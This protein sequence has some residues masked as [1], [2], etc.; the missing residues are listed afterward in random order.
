MPPLQPA[1]TAAGGGG[2]GSG[3]SGSLSGGRLGGEVGVVDGGGVG[4]GGLKAAAPADA[5]PTAAAAPAAPAA[6][7]K[8]SLFHSILFGG[9]AGVI[10]QTTVFPMYSVK[11]RMHTAP[12]RYSSAFHCIS[13]VLQHEGWRGLYRG[14]PPALLGVFPEKAIKLGVNDHLRERLAAPDGSLSIGMSMMAGAGAGF[15]QVIATNPMEMVMITMQTRSLQGRKSKSMAKV[16]R[17]LGLAGLYRG[18]SATLARD[19]PFSVVFFS[20]RARLEEAMADKS[21]KTPMSRV[22][23]AGIVSGSTAAALSTPM[24]V[25]KTRLM[26]AGGMA[27]TGVPPARMLPM[28]QKIWVEEGARGFFNGAVPRMLI[29]SPLFGITLLF[30]EVQIRWGERKKAKK[31]EADTGG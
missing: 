17:G 7:A 10:G 19:V 24:D 4:G 13:K 28:I 30:Y 2:G 15:S 5:A 18:T 22:F 3:P 12:G 11:T 27:D 8:M 29:I 16:I 25:V 20:L 26:A 21:G 6:K 1:A 14:M 31:A 23:V 9:T